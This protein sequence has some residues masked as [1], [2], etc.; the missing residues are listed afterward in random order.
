MS[1]E[2]NNEKKWDNDLDD[3]GFEID[4]DIC[5]ENQDTVE[6]LSTVSETQGREHAK[7]TAIRVMITGLVLML[8][9]A[10]LWRLTVNN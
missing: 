8:I 5:F 4:D 6:E 1:A 10:G 3:V 2:D 9:C 7:K